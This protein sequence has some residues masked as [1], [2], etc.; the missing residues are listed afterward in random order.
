MPNSAESVKRKRGLLEAARTEKL[1]EREAEMK[2]KLQIP[3]PRTVSLNHR[4]VIFMQ[5]SRFR[6]SH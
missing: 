2:P 3:E 5:Q 1:K 6:P 4:D